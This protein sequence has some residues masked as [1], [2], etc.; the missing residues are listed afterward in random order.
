MSVILICARPCRHVTGRWR[1]RVAEHML[2]GEPLPVSKRAGDKLTGATLNIE[3]HG[4]AMAPTGMT[5]RLTVLQGSERS[6]AELTVVGDR[7][8]AQ[9]VKLAPGARVV[10]ALTT[11]A[12]KAITVRFTVK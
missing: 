9:G 3:D 6:Q 7:L 11:P 8:E 1:R 2:T 5:G 10:A 4:K 12:K